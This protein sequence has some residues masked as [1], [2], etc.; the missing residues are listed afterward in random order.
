V[1]SSRHARPRPVRRAPPLNAAAASLALASALAWGTADFWGGLL[2]RRLPALAVTVVSQLAGFAAV[3]VALA[4]V[5]GALEGRS[6][7]LGLLAGLGGGAGLAAYYRALALGTMSIVSPLAACG[8]LVPFAISI[9]TGERPS[10]LGLAGAALALVGAV[11]VSLPE[12]RS[13]VPERARAVVLAAGAAL[14]LG[15]FTYFLGLG[16]RDGSA[17]STLVGARVGSLAVLSAFALVV[18][19]PPRVGRRLLV[20][21]AAVGLCDVGANALFAVA[22]RHGLLAL[23]SVLGSL[24]PVVTVLLARALLGERLGRLQ[25][26]AVVIALTGVSALAAS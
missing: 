21:V 3:L 15:L 2:S 12:R 1:R 22:S 16:S 13:Q 25:W 23:V 26:C 24:Y 9:A 10:A 14:A 4:A 6:F 18:R 17:L 20:P 5:G 8:A 7:E 19:E 11:A